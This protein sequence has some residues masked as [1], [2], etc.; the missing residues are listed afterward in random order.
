MVLRNGLGLVSTTAF[1]DISN[2]FGF[3]GSGICELLACLDRAVFLDEF[4]EKNEFIFANISRYQLAPSDWTVKNKQ[5]LE[6]FN[7]EMV[8]QK[9]TF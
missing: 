9:L 7:H 5:T 2:S 8:Q 3:F 6:H 1:Y 4:S